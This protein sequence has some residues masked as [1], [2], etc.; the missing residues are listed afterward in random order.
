MLSA[1]LAFAQAKGGL[2]NL[3]AL[4][5]GGNCFDDAC[6]AAFAQALVCT[7]LLVL[8]LLASSMLRRQAERTPRGRRRSRASASTQSG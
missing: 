3:T 1:A 6:A 7:V 8:A 4:N 2:A 5:L